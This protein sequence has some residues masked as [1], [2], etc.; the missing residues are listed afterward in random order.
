LFGDRA[1]QDAFFQA[2]VT[3]WRIP[4]MDDRGGCRPKS[5]PIHYTL[6]YRDTS[7][8]LPGEFMTCFLADGNAQVW[9]VD[10][11]TLTIGAVKRPGD[12]NTL[13][14][15]DLWWSTTILAEL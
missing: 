13:D 6:Y 10:T 9:W 11:R 8:P 14:R 15:L 3:R 5:D 7:G 12:I 4:R 1:T 2:L